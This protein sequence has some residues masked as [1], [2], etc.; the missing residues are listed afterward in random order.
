MLQVVDL[1]KSFGSQVLF[2]N[3]SFTLGKGEKL[4]LVGRNGHG[5]TTLFKL[6]L[7][8]EHPDSGRITAPSNYRIGHLSQKLGF[9]RDTVRDEGAMGLRPEERDQVYKVESVLCGL[10]FS[11]ADLDRPPGQFSGGLQVRLNLAKLLVS[12]PNLLLLDEPTNYLDIVSLRWLHR[13]LRSWKNELILITHDR[14]FMDSVTT[15]TM[16]IHRQ[17]VRRVKGP[18]QK[19]YDQLLAEEEIYEKTRRTEEKKRREIEQ[20]IDRFRAQARRASIVQSRIKSLE[21][22][23][24]REDL[25]QI[26]SLDFRFSEAPFAAQTILDVRNLEFSFSGSR[27]LISDLSF[28]VSREDRIG[29]IGRNGKGKTTLLRLITGELSPSS[30]EV[31]Y[32]PEVRSGYFGQTNIDRLCPDRTVEEEVLSANPM[33]GRSQVRGVCGVMMFPGSDAEKRVGVLSGGERSRALVAKILAQPTNL[34]LLDEPTSHLDMDSV[35]SLVDAL[36]AYRGAV[37]IVTHSEMILRS[38]AR[39]L[40]VFHRDRVEFF[41]GTYDEFL[42]KLGWEDQEIVEAQAAPMVESKRSSSRKTD[43]QKRSEIVAERSR[44][45]GPLK[46]RI[47]SLEEEITRLER[48]I[49]RDSESLIE[50][51]MVGKGERIGVLGKAISQNRAAVDRLFDE[52]EQVTIEYETETARFTRLLDQS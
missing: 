1:S 41:N 11:M 31:K 34:L 51:S 23:G 17:K 20:F 2:D 22:M 3:V 50:A 16:G 5:K 6:I 9:T 49:Q 8:D 12:E 36:K 40:I 25:T 38:L 29:V 18:T 33:L 47:D 7:G 30:G 24:S 42:E 4:G 27:K 46:R 35:E 32:H 45:T 39:R 52:L 44:V 21:R 26:E 19:L 37:L 10:G 28:F 15:Y 14:E 43:R 13:F 48:E